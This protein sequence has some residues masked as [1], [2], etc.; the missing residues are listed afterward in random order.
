MASSDVRVIGPGDEPV[1]ART[2]D[3][4]DVPA[5]RGHAGHRDQSTRV[6]AG[7]KAPDRHGFKYGRKK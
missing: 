4:K 6:D 2:L 7:D 3:R 1:N 5:Y